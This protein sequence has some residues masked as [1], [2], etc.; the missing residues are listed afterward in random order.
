MFSQGQMIFGVI[1]FIVFVIATVFMYRKD[2]ATHKV[3]YKGS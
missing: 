2:I 1:F 3:Y